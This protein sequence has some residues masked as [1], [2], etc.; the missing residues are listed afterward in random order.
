[1]TCRHSPGD[2]SC[3][4]Y[5]RYEPDE[6]KTPDASNY[7]IE[8]MQRVNDR[9][10]VLQVKYPNCAKCA[11]EGLKTLVYLDITEMDMLKWKKIDPHFRAP[12][13]PGVKTVAPSPVARFPGTYDGFKD[14]IMYLELKVAR[15]AVD[16]A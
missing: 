2:P 3:S 14:A 6:P 16:G 5:S 13:S 4:S 15:L 1:M 9:H 12:A 10:V 11:F 8:K 7:S